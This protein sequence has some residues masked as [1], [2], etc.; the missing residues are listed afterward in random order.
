MASPAFPT[1]PIVLATVRGV[2]ASVRKRL[3][4]HSSLFHAGRELLREST[5][6]EA[7]PRCGKTGPVQEVRPVQE[8][9]GKS[10]VAEEV[11]PVQ[12]RGGKSGARAVQE[13][14]GGRG[15]AGANLDGGK[16]LPSD[17]WLWRLQLR[18]IKNTFR[19]R[20]YTQGH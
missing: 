13:R 2:A 18:F 11:R 19:C 6:R 8:R 12:E 10:G 5:A 16:G 7:G 17:G 14:G 4:T 3:M 1:E 15:P 20:R 9:G